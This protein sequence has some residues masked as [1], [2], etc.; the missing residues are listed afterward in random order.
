VVSN[1]SYTGK[2]N[3]FGR[4]PFMGSSC[5]FVGSNSWGRGH[6][7]V[8]EADYVNKKAMLHAWKEKERDDIDF[9]RQ[10]GSCESLLP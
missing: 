6:E 4:E 7:A 9:V 10:G 2:D 8:K 1:A 3:A 5:F